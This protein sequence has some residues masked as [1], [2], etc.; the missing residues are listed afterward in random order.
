[1][2]SND[3]IEEELP[4]NPFPVKLNTP[5]GHHR[6]VG[7]SHIIGSIEGGCLLLGGWDY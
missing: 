1:M 7:N 3:F 5:Q 2:I 4:T 6:L